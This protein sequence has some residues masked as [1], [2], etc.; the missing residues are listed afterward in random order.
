MSPQ[1]QFPEKDSGLRTGPL[2]SAWKN[3]CWATF[4]IWKWS[5]PYRNSHRPDDAT[6]ASV[7]SAN[8]GPEDFRRLVHLHFPSLDPERLPTNEA[9]CRALLRQKFS[10]ANSVGGDVGEHQNQR[11]SQDSEWYKAEETWKEIPCSIRYALA[12]SNALNL[13]KKLRLVLTQ[14]YHPSFGLN[15]MTRSTASITK[16]FRMWRI[17]F[18]SAISRQERICVSIFFVILAFSAVYPDVAAG[19]LGERSYNQRSIGGRIMTLIQLFFL[20]TYPFHSFWLV[21]TWSLERL[22]GAFVGNSIYALVAL[23]PRVR[24]S[25]NAAWFR[26][27]TLVLSIC[28]QVGVQFSPAVRDYLTRLLTRHQLSSQRLA[29]PNSNSTAIPKETHWELVSHSAFI[30]NHLRSGDAPYSWQEVPIKVRIERYIQFTGTFTLGRSADQLVALLKDDMERV[31]STYEDYASSIPDNSASILDKAD[32]HAE[33]RW[34][35][36]ILVF[37][38][39]GLFAYINYSFWRQPFTFNTTIAYSTVVIIKQTILAVRRYQTVKSAGRLFTNMVSVNILGMLLVSTPVTV[40]PKVL[41]NDTNMVVL[42]LAMVFATLFLVELI[43]PTILLL[44]SHAG[45]ILARIKSGFV[46]ER[47]VKKGNTGGTGR[48][49]RRDCVV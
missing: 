8:V 31:I 47:N 11:S 6:Y 24:A 7:W 42:T 18:G 10:S 22:L 44:A 25:Y 12:A 34:P 26:T 2:K 13:E 49:T 36:L 48:E 33:P 32:S 14:S 28:W 20:W 40:N 45:K 5:V 35:K 37:F 17:G 29:D 38:D 3:L 39:I 19:F 27:M 23:V 41:E 15:T 30:N 43:A 46:S 1:V 9:Q 4:Q 21:F 16:I